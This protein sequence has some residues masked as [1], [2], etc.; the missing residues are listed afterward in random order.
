MAIYHCRWWRMSDLNSYF[1]FKVV[2]GIWL[3]IISIKSPTSYLFLSS[4]SVIQLFVC[5][6]WGKLTIFFNDHRVVSKWVVRGKNA[7]IS[8]ADNNYSVS[9]I[10]LEVN[11]PGIWRWSRIYGRG[12]VSPMELL[13]EIQDSVPAFLTGEKA[14]NR[15]TKSFESEHPFLP[16]RKLRLELP[17]LDH[18]SEEVDLSRP[19]RKGST[20]IG[21]TTSGQCTRMIQIIWYAQAAITSIWC[22][23]LQ[24]KAKLRWL[25]VECNCN[26]PDIELRFA[27]FLSISLLLPARTQ[28]KY[29]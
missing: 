4:I 17:T 5:I 12:L 8:I 16:I 11:R 7:Q 3:L 1:S 13:R 27:L 2:V 29:V 22:R 6:M 19:H 23:N 26:C 28:A 25:V 14:P 21:R 24:Q 10:W 9:L 20:W 18:T 15:M